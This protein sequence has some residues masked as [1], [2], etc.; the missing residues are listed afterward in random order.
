MARKFRKVKKSKKGV[1]KAYL[2]GSKNKKKS[3]REIL[4]TRKLYKKGKL[5]PKMMD[6]ISRKRVASGKKKKR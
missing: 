5:T 4:R 6:A 1:P 2:S 3:E